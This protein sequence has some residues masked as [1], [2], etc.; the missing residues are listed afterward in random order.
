M[1]L[2]LLCLWVILVGVRAVRVGDFSNEAEVA[3][4]GGE[5]EEEVKISAFP[6][7]DI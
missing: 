1:S 4:G 2:P 3:V 5:E 6:M 7:F